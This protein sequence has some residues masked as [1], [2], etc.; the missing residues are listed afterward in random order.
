MVPPRTTPGLRDLARQLGLS[1]TT[2]SRALKDGD[3]V[4]PETIARVKEAARR[5]GYVPNLQGLSL[6]TGR[7][8]TICAILPMVTTGQL[9]DIGKMPLVEGMTEA[10]E[11]R[12][13]SLTMLSTL[14]NADPLDTVRQAVEG[15]QCDGLIITRMHAQDIRA[16]YL[17]ER[18]FPFVAFGQTELFTPIPFLDIDNEDFAYRATRRL[19]ERGHRRIALQAAPPEM[20]Y[21]G[22][23]VLGYRRAL[24][25]AGLPYDAALVSLTELGIDESRVAVV[26]LLALDA[27][28]TAFICASEICALGALAGAKDA[29]RRIG[30]DVSIVSRDCTTMTAYF[31]PPL[32]S[33]FVSM[34]RIGQR[35]ME[36]LLARIDGAD[37]AALQEIIKVEEIERCD[38]SAPSLLQAKG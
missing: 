17:L 1:V 20:V 37:A 22:R 6:R 38:D 18:G 31:D 26:N 2:V 32:T 13:Y 21:A 12:S 34:D 16:K 7:T 9:G 15:R 4:K 33:Y 11:G 5:S 3:D 30:T 25:E 35:L 24:A 29:G 8:H 36:M 14:P 19:I 23:R 10:L 28:P 27:P